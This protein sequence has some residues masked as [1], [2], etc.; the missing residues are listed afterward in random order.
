MS[1]DDACGGFYPNP[2]PQQVCPHCGRCPVCGQR[3]GR[4]Y[5]HVYDPYDPYATRWAPTTSSNIGY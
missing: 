5:L 1:T 3:D 4:A 2:E